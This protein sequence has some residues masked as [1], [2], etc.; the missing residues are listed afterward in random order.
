MSSTQLCNCG[1]GRRG[2]L[3]I[4]GT[5]A[6]SA[7]L[8]RS[9]Y[10]ETV[11][12]TN[13]GANTCI[14]WQ[15]FQ[16]ADYIASLKAAQTV[17]ASPLANAM[18]QSP[19]ALPGGTGGASKR[20]QFMIELGK[21]VPPPETNPSGPRRSRLALERAKLWNRDRVVRWT[22]VN[23]GPDWLIK[24]INKAFE[25]W[26]SYLEMKLERVTGM[27]AQISVGFL[28][29]G[30][31]SLVG[32]DS[33]SDDLRRRF[34]GQSLN[35]QPS[36]QH[37]N[38]RAVA[39]HEIGHALGAIHEHQN[40]DAKIPW[41]FAALQR[42]YGTGSNNPN[43]WSDDEIRYQ[44]TNRY[45]SQVTNFTEYDKNSI[46]CY[47]IKAE[48][49]DRQAPNW[50][51]YV[52]SWNTVLS[53]QDI[54]FMQKHYGVGPDGATIPPGGGGPAPTDNSQAKVSL[55]LDQKLAGEISRDG[56]FTDYEI[57]VIK[58]GTYVIETIERNPATFMVL[59]FFENSNGTK[60]KIANSLG[61]AGLLNSRLELQLA[62]GKY[63][64]RARHRHLSGRGKYIIHFHS[65]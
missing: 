49:L 23:Q 48:H 7:Y 4:A 22:Y 24:V 35:I 30:F 45:D 1:I 54:A 62:T 53:P 38:F 14:E 61:G 15:P 8:P 65:K 12:P 29:S 26:G 16:E 40:P 27:T 18:A 5:A 2:F 64:I 19:Q 25:E 46:M 60:P 21:E 31:F 59:E 39:L 55:A 13:P 3:G 47:P 43:R 20:P 41:N 10:A 42:E 17:H 34:S 52:H 32:T 51:K 57:T 33:A 63:V 11:D 36:A 28:H 58:S 6:L 56:S 9:T 50:E 44:I 37:P